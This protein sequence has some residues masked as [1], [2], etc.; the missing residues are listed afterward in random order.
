MYISNLFIQHCVYKKRRRNILIRII[1]VALS[2]AITLINVFTIFM[3]LA[4]T[5]L[6]C[7]T[8]QLLFLCVLVTTVWLAVLAFKY[9]IAIFKI[10][11]CKWYLLLGRVSNHRIKKCVNQWSGIQT[12]DTQIQNSIPQCFKLFGTSI[13]KRKN[14]NPGEK[15]VLLIQWESLFRGQCMRRV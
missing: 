4:Y 9:V 11:I 12:T 7:R 5:M 8:C 13:H 6:F 3:A 2:C 15:V 14:G 1:S 10:T